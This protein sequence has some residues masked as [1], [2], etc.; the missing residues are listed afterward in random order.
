MFS[1]I[2]EYIKDENLKIN[3]YKD[4]VNIINYKSIL[5]FDDDKILFYYVDPNE[6]SFI[7]MIDILN[8]KEVSYDNR[9]Y[10]KK[11]IYKIGDDK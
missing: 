2:L 5:V 6:V 1:K 3:L 9:F 10:E 4:K 7:N 8:G 11:T